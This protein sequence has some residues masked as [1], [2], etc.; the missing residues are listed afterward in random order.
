MAS[1]DFST[2]LKYVVYATPEEVYNALTDPSLMEQW[3]EGTFIFELKEKGNI[4]FFDD[5]VKGE[6]KGFVPNKTLSYT[7]KPNTWSKKTKPSLVEIVFTNVAAG[8]ELEITHTD[9]PNADEA[10]KH[11]EGWITYF[12]EPLND[13]FIARMK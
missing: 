12:L 6:I 9:F 3:I 4:A 8:T 10:S 2:H 7:W 11:R 5:W 13:Y 1:Q